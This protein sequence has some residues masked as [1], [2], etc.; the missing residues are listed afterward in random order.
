VQPDIIDMLI[1]PASFHVSGDHLPAVTFTPWQHAKHAVPIT[2]LAPAIVAMPMLYQIV[3]QLQIFTLA[4]HAT[5]GISYTR[6]V[7]MLLKIVLWQL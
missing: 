6:S 2:Y 4:R 3:Q 5:L 7:L 1:Q